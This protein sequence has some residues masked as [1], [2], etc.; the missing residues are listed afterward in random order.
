[1]CLG[2]HSRVWILSPRLPHG[3]YRWLEFASQKK[4]RSKDKKRHHPAESA[5][6]RLPP[7]IL[8]EFILLARSK[9]HGCIWQQWSL[10]NHIF[11]LIPM[12]P[13]QN[14]WQRYLAGKVFC[15]NWWKEMYHN[16]KTFFTEVSFTYTNMHS[17]HM[18]ILGSFNR[19]LHLSN[20]LLNQDYR[21]FRHPRKCPHVPF[22]SGLH[23]VSLIQRQSLF[24]I[25][26][27]QLRLFSG[28]PRTSLKP[29]KL[30]RSGNI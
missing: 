4:K 18:Y 11:F 17:F 19:C 3:P 9:S 5:P 26:S 25:P 20:R 8:T 16:F 27:P 23:P 7:G 24:L 28:T 12:C 14:R 13:V 15:I 6:F 1:M 22:Q 30:H 2:L 21:T 29:L 10:G